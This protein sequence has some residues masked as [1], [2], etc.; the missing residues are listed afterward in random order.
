MTSW[1]NIIVKYRDKLIC[2]QM[3][4]IEPYIITLHYILYSKCCYFFFQ[5]KSILPNLLGGF[6]WYLKNYT[7]KIFFLFPK[8][9]EN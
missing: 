8:K 7:N 9:R 3:E 4:K 6:W 2:S 5:L 1:N